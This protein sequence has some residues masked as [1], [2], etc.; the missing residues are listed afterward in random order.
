MRRC[1]HL[2]ITLRAERKHFL[3]DRRGLR[4]VEQGG[5]GYIVEHRAHRQLVVYSCGQPFEERIRL[6]WRYKA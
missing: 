6:V 2:S 1:S 4:Y 5:P 3:S